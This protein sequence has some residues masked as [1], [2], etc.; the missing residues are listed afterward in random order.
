MTYCRRCLMP[1][2]KPYI[3]FDEAGV[4]NAC[5]AHDRKRD[6]EDGIDWQ[7][8]KHSFDR[9]IRDVKARRAPFYDVVVPVSGGKDSISQVHRLL[10]HDLRILAVSVDYGIKTEIGHR[11][12]G[13]VAGMGAHLM[14]YTPGDPLHRE[15]IRL[16][17]EE[18]GDPDL[19]SHC[20]LH[21]FPLRVA[22]KFD[23]PLVWLGENSAFEY[24]GS[25]DLADS[26]A[27]TRAWYDRYAANAGMT[28]RRLADVRGLP[29][30]RL[31]VYDF[32]DEIET[33]RTTSA[34]FMSWF[35]PWD[36]ET[37]LEIA[38]RYGFAAL[39]HASEGTYR[40]YVGIDEKINRIHQ[41]LK[42]LK[43]GYGRATDHACEDIRSGR[44]TR[45]EAKELVRRHDLVP[46]SDYFI[47]DFCEFIGL[48]RAAFLDTL[49]R[50]R[51]RQIWQPA[52]DG[53]WHIPN[54][55]AD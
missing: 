29:Y 50:Y 42:V 5:T 26:N 18:Y 28:P 22:L 37:H 7:A 44:L 10:G 46:L 12:L 6:A 16:G 17:L 48:E 19:M 35:F 52:A 51:N 21:A 39:D 47:D 33:S 43:F 25:R 11:N 20:L 15:L 34:L 36:S 41:Y 53:S 32:P 45:D 54:H 1:D 14:V 38:R 49:E 55:V 2:T 3:R 13:C 4:C 30:E 23:V 27:M 24:G 8:R 40:G 31:Q 9:L